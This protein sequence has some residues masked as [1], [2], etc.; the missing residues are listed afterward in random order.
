MK[1]YLFDTHTFI[2]CQHKYFLFSDLLLYNDLTYY[3][4]GSIYA[5]L[6][7]KGLHTNIEHRNFIIN[8]S[9]LLENLTFLKVFEC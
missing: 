5:T 6:T 4:R 1:F 8:T 3:Q 2:L 9:N 7:D